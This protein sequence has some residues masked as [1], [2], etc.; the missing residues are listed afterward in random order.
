MN[1]PDSTS[2]AVAAYSCGNAPM[3]ASCAMNRLLTFMSSLAAPVG[4][5]DWRL[6]AA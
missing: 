1:C 2:S 4:P 6:V 5:A 3:A